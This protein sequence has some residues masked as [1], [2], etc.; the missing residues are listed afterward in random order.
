MLTSSEQAQIA[1]FFR[2]PPANLSEPASS[3]ERPKDTLLMLHRGSNTMAGMDVTRLMLKTH[4]I[5][6]ERSPEKSPAK[7][8]STLGVLNRK[9]R[10][11]GGLGNGEGAGWGFVL[12]QCSLCLTDQ[13]PE[14]RTDRT[15][16][17]RHTRSGVPWQRHGALPHPAEQRPQTP[18]RQRPARARHGT[19]TYMASDGSRTRPPVCAC[20]RDCEPPILSVPWARG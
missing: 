15:C 5:R 7:R 12:W 13:A 4:S 16:S 20:C 1:S 9:H 19:R 18:P 2:P 11:G 6:A 3:E 8:S 10:G 17:G 14:T